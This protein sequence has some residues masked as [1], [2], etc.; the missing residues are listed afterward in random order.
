LT[1]R[2]VATSFISV[3]TTTPAALRSSVLALTAFNGDAS[4]TQVT[5]PTRVYLADL[6]LDGDT[7]LRRA[8]AHASGAIRAEFWS[9]AQ[10][11]AE[12]YARDLRTRGF[13]VEARSERVECGEPQKLEVVAVLAEAA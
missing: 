11:A 10:P 13:V 7:D 12:A 9:D 1:I 5:D 8:E 6:E 2:H 3:S 4:W